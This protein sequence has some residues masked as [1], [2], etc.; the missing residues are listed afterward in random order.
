MLNDVPTCDPAA[1]VSPRCVSE[2]EYWKKILV[3]SPP[4][5]PQDLDGE[6][7]TQMQDTVGAISWDLNGKLA[8][9]VSRSVIALACSRTH[10]VHSGGLLLKYPGRIGEVRNGTAVLDDPLT[11]RRPQ[12][13]VLDAGHTRTP[14]SVSLVVYQV[15]YNTRHS[16]TS[17]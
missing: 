16:Q 14:E 6:M 17:R 1:L 10:L 3:D 5:I 11:H 12:Y 8:A 4:P 7:P 9:G 13:S 15:R 2:W